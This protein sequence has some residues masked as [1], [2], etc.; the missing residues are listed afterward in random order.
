[1][2]IREFNII[3]STFEKG[4]SLPEPILRPSKRSELL[5]PLTNLASSTSN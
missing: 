4:N 5:M 2:S 3:D 1:M